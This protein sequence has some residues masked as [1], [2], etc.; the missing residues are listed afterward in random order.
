M[1]IITTLNRMFLNQFTQEDKAQ[2]MTIEGAQAVALLYAKLEHA[3]AVLSDLK[4]NKSYIYKGALAA[5]MG[6][7][8]ND[9]EEIDSIW[10]DE[11]YR[12]IHPDDL[13]NRHLLEL[14]Y[15]QLLKNL[16]IKERAHYHTESRIRVRDKEGEY[17]AILHRTFYMNPDEQEQLRLALCLY[18]FSSNPILPVVFEG[19]ILNTVTGEVI[20]PDHQKCNMLLTVREKEILCLIK[21]GKLSK[22][23]AALLSISVHTINRHRQNILE[24]LRVN[25]SIEALKVAEG[26]GL[27]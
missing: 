12:E 7:G 21:Q 13:L 26:L 5:T 15:F 11:I 24:K 8:E 9:C 25:N 1:N 2:N 3:V 16:S 10:E 27:I 22:E 4:T 23:I 20:R 19:V 6:W 17:K 14:Q 18:N